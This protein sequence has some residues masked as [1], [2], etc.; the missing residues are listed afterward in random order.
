MVE[1]L[2]T[3]ALLLATLDLG[4]TM[5]KQKPLSHLNQDESVLLGSVQVVMSGSWGRRLHWR[6]GVSAIEEQR[7]FNSQVEQNRG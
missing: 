1:P 5:S 2:A 6:R 3:E 4:I 7:R